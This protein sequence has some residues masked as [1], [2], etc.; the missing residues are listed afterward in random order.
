MKIELDEIQKDNL[1]NG[2]KCFLIKSRTQMDIHSKQHESFINMFC[3]L[4]VGDIAYETAKEF[5]C[6]WC[7]GKDP[8]CIDCYGTGKI[9]DVDLQLEVKSIKCIK[10][11]DINDEELIKLGMIDFEF[12]IDEIF[13]QGAYEAN[14]YYFLVEVE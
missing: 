7:K 14:E 6:S 13:G 5:E 11:Q 2:G 3:Q 4:K 9:W 8:H 1:N 10:A 12:F